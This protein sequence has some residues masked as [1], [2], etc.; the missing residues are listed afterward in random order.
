MEQQKYTLQR[1]IEV[2]ENIIRQAVT[3]SETTQ[4]DVFVDY[5]PH[6]NTIYLDFYHAGWKMDR[7]PDKKMQV[8]F[9]YWADTETQIQ[10]AL[11]ELGKLK[12]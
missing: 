11:H 6:T 3:I 12:S 2:A 7:I 10:N 9:E 8:C 1:K 4:A 5:A